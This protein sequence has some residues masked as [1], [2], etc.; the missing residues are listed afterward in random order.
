MRDRKRDD[1]LVSIDIAL[2]EEV[3]KILQKAEAM[4]NILEY[5]IVTLQS[6]L[7]AYY[8]LHNYWSELPTTDSTA[9][10]I[11]KRNLVMALDEKMW[12][13]ITA[14]LVAAS[15]LLKSFSFVKDGKERRNLLEQAV[16]AAR[17]NVMHY[18]GILV[19]NDSDTSDLED[20]IATAECPD[21]ETST[22]KAKYDPFAEFI[23]VASGILKSIG[24]VSEYWPYIRF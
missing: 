22:K 3:L 23:N 5:Y 18:D 10:S 11:L 9:G 14:P 7:P 16:Q 8:L 1:L 12:M 15:Y 21:N 24:H 13:D 4:F 19:S 2:L 17:E 6:V 20:M